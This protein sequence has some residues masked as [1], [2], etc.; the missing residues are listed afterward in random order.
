MK[1]NSK[2]TH[3]EAFKEYSVPAFG[4]EMFREVLV[5]EILGHEYQSMLYWAGKKLARKFPIETVEGISDF[6]LSAGFGTL[7]L[8]HKNRNEMEFELEG[9][10]IALRL[11][12]MKEPCFQLE[13]GFIAQQLE[14]MN[15]QVTE[16]YEQVKKRG[17][18]IVFTVK[19]DHKDIVLSNR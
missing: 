1:K 10:L 18:K 7:T 16:S 11:Q 8:I 13:A 5:P 17:N 15:E 2:D 14:Q 19:W 12:E 9:E 4:Y 3:L 6:F